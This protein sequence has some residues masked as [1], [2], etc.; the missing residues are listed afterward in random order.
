MMAMLYIY[1]VHVECRMYKDT[2]IYA[3]G[4]VHPLT[5]DPKSRSKSGLSNTGD[6]SFRGSLTWKR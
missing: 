5:N 4:L 6:L 2:D 3:V 1:I